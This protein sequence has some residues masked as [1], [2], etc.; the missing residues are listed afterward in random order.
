MEK[1]HLVFT[2]EVNNI[3][4]EFIGCNVNKQT[5][6]SSC[7]AT[8]F[9]QENYVKDAVKKFLDTFCLNNKC[10]LVCYSF[11]RLPYPIYSPKTNVDFFI[12]EKWEDIKHNENTLLMIDTFY[13]KYERECIK[14]NIKPITKVL[15]ADEYIE[16][17][18]NQIMDDTDRE[19][20]Y[21]FIFHNH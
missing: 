8:L 4:K 5:I 2:I 3:V 12:N 1:I 7:T 20:F 11:V 6:K 14:C 10:T 21:K 17:M 16:Q 13:S 18:L 15:V 19:I 9:A